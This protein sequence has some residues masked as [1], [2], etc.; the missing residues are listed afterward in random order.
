VALNKFNKWGLV[1][2]WGAETANAHD[3]ASHPLV[4]RFAERMIVRADTTF[5][6]TGRTPSNLKVCPRGAWND[7]MLVETTFPML[8]LVCHTKKAAHRA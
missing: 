6:R 7:R 4:T 8:T 3:S 2:A 1:C 5:G